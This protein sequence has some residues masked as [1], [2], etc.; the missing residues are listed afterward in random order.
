MLTA[1]GDS[2]KLLTGATEEEEGATMWMPKG[3]DGDAWDI[4][5]DFLEPLAAMLWEWQN[6]LTM[7]RV[8]AGIR[9]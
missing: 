1:A 8:S 6:N 7:V 2:A 4:C 5:G 3:F 9:P